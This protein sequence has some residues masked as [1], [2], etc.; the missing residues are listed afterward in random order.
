MPTTEH[1]PTVFEFLTAL[2]GLLVVL[3][4]SIY[5]SVRLVGTWSRVDEELEKCEQRERRLREEL[6]HA[7]D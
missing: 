2:F 1:A 6:S 5:L 4:F 7:D 3:P